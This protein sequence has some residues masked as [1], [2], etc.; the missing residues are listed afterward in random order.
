MIGVSKRGAQACGVLGMLVVALC[1]AP[2]HGTAEPSAVAPCTPQTFSGRAPAY[3]DDAMAPSN[4]V[5]LDPVVAGGDPFASNFADAGQV[6]RYTPIPRYFTAPGATL[7]IHFPSGTDGTSVV[8]AGRTIAVT[9]NGS[10]GSWVVPADTAGVESGALI[11][12]TRMG[13]VDTSYAF[14]IIVPVPGSPVPQGPGP[15]MTTCG[16][17]PPAVCAAYHGRLVRLAREQS[18]EEKRLRQEH[19]KEAR[20]RI[21]SAL[22]RTQAMIARQKALYAGGCP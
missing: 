18:Q 6:L 13:R 20:A 8:F 15:L 11:G 7:R 1:A 21:L 22:R 4:A 17:P 12:S 16:A 2:T 9:M 14:E 19:N 5:W 10:I 3:L